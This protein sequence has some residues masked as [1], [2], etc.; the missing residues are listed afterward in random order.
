MFTKP[1][2]RVP[3]YI[4]IKS[5][6]VAISLSYLPDLSH[7]FLKRIK[8]YEAKLHVKST[9]FCTDNSRTSSLS[10][11]YHI[12]NHKNF[13]PNISIMLLQISLKI[14]EHRGGYN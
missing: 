13:I 3:Q 2:T 14:H 10:I 8:V 4:L 5:F 6:F 9:L 7:K 11:V 1:L 12:S